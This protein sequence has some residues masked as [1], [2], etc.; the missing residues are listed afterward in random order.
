MKWTAEDD[1]KLLLIGLH[2]PVTGKQLD[3]I[4]HCF[5]GNPTDRALFDRLRR[6]RSEQNAILNTLSS[7]IPAEVEELNAYER[8]TATTSVLPPSGWAERFGISAEFWDAVESIKVRSGN[9]QASKSSCG[10]EGQE[11]QADDSG[12][13]DDLDLLSRLIDHDPLGILSDPAIELVQL[14]STPTVH[15]A[16]QQELPR[17]V[18]NSADEDNKCSSG[19]PTV[20]GKLVQVSISQPAHTVA[21]SEDDDELDTGI[22]LG[23]HTVVSSTDSLT[24]GEF[25]I[26][27]L[28]SPRSNNHHRVV[29]ACQKAAMATPPRGRRLAFNHGSASI[30]DSTASPESPQPSQS[31]GSGEACLAQFD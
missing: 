16:D 19:A 29:A 5:K 2:R 6:L 22:G 26:L 8:S 1:R 31:L 14:A 21:T 4:R 9:A 23:N 20:K 30:R 28:A 18:L 27:A 13:E 24:A 25:G 15:H 12:S 7:I 17:I 10:G 3:I 11:G